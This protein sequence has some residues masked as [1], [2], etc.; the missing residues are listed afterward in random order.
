MDICGIPNLGNTHVDVPS[1][2]QWKNYAVST[3]PA[4]QIATHRYSQHLC[5]Q[6]RIGTRNQVTRNPYKVVPTKYKWRQ[7]DVFSPPEYDRLIKGSWEA[8]LPCYG[9]KEL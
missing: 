6:L 2:S 7:M 1:F 5:H 4:Q 9:Q 8:I 3:S